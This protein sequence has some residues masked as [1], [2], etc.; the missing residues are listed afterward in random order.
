MQPNNN[1]S[2]VVRKALQVC[3][4]FIGFQLKSLTTYPSIQINKELLS[5]T[6]S[7]ILIESSITLFLLEILLPYSIELLKLEVFF[8]FWVKK[9]CFQSPLFFLA[10]K[11]LI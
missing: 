9:L 2:F 7:S 5:F 6:T 4:F 8:V 1:E 10:L 11:K 3:V